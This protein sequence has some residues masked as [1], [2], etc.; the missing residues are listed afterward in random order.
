MEAHAGGPLNAGYDRLIVSGHG[1]ARSRGMEPVHGVAS[2][3][4]SSTE[5]EQV[6]PRRGFAIL[7]AQ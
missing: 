2:S 3:H 4:V 7:S 6:K 5:E 1:L